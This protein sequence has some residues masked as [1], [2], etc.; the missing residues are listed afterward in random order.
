M[1]TQLAIKLLSNVLAGFV[2]EEC[3]SPD[4]L[5]VGIWSGH[6]ELT[7]LELKEDILDLIGLPI[8]LRYAR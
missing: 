4:L 6:V 8:G 7:N 3:F 1:L 2:K 5:Q